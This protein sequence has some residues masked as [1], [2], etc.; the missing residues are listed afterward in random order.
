MAVTAA[1]LA[2]GGR[3]EFINRNFEGQVDGERM[4]GVNGVGKAFVF[5]RH[6]IH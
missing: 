6:D 1:T 4:Y 3:Y 2:A 5:R